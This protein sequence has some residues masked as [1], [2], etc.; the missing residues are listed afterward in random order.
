MRATA[1]ST[2]ASAQAGKVLSTIG[3]A[4]GSPYGA[5]LQPDGKIVVAGVAYDPATL[6]ALARF[7]ADGS[8]DTAFGVNGE[9][10]SDVSP[11]F[12]S[13]ISTALQPDGKVLLAG[14]CAFQFCVARYDSDGTLDASFGSGGVVLGGQPGYPRALAL[15]PDGKI[16]VA[17]DDND[18]SGSPSDFNFKLRRLNPDGSPDT[19]FQ[20]GG[21]AT[22]AIGEL[23]DLALAV[24]LQSSGRIV[25]AGYTTTT[26]VLLLELRRGAL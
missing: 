6:F 18:G 15:Q 17:G 3:P 10:L 11:S 16:V 23:D 8:V 26:L 1:A 14:T 2:R 12:D 13:G 4:R 21:V 22:A 20:G 25:M 7:E 5:L 19:S 24:R 9:V